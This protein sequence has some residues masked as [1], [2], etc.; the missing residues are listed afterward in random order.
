MSANIVCTN[1]SSR[2]RQHDS[3]WMD[4]E[5]KKY[6]FR[7]ALAI[8]PKGFCTLNIED[9]YASSSVL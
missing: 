4:P 1:P 8:H 5:Q 3:T 2:A 7:L 9:L 6:S